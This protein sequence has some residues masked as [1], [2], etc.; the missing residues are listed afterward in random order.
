MWNTQSSIKRNGKRKALTTLGGELK[1]SRNPRFRSTTGVFNSPP[2]CSRPRFD[3]KLGLDTD[4]KNGA[5]KEP[6]GELWILRAA[7][8]IETATVWI[9][10]ATV[11]TYGARKEPTGEFNSLESGKA[12]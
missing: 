8:W 6:T 10:R 12:A 5:I 1:N 3:K 2:E 7:L 4:N 9:L 11:Q